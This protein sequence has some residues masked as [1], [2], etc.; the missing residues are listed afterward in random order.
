MFKIYCLVLVFFFTSQNILSQ[1]ISAEMIHSISFQKQGENKSSNFLIGKIN[2]R[3]L[4]SFDVLSGIEYDLYYIIDHCDYNWEKSKL[5]KSEYIEG[6]DDV[7]ITNYTSSFN[8]YQI[9]TNY[10][11][12]FPNSNTSV[13]KSGNYIIRIFDEYG[14][15][16]FNRKFIIYE[17]LSLVKVDIKRSKELK[18]INEKQIVNFEVNPNNI[19]FNNPD[20]NVKT[21]VFKNSNIDSPI[22][23]IKPQYKIGNKLI[24]K[25]DKELSFWGGN[26]YLYFDNKN[27]RITNVKIRGYNLKEI[28][29]NYLFNDYPRF[30]RKYTYNPDIN[31]GFLINA[32]NSGNSNNEADYANIYFTLENYNNYLNNDQDIYIVG[33]FNNYSTDKVYK[34]Q[35]NENKNQFEAVLKLKQGF[36]NYKYLIDN[37]I[38]KNDNKSVG[39]NFDETENVYSVLVYYRDYGERYDR[40]V[41]FG[42]GSSEFITN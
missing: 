11:I 35:F 22:T 34:M 10:N 36:Y 26:E 7:K 6:F 28:Y 41:G 9:Y 17:N 19:R 31:G 12:T 4:I 39:G 5:L 32:S 8:T 33:D 23:N 13:K 40:I 20:K 42:K 29:E 21:L 1:D 37:E 16:L 2:D 15:E 27:I 30:N 38:Y 14:E 24:Y 18:N 25:Y 3:F